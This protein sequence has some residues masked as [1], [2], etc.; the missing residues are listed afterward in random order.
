M[1]EK[2]SPK[3]IKK[4]IDPFADKPIALPEGLDLENHV[5]AT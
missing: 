4:E 5:V 2:K 1:K 3:V